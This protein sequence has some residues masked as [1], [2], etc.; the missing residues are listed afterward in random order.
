MHE[1]VCVATVWSNHTTSNV[2][3]WV[4]ACQCNLELEKSMTSSKML[5]GSLFRDSACMVSLL[6]KAWSHDAT[7]STLT[8]PERLATGVALRRNRIVG[9][10]ESSRMFPWHCCIPFFVLLSLSLSLAFSPS[11]Q[12]QPTPFSYIYHKVGAQTHVWL[13]CDFFFSLI[14]LSLLSPD[15]SLKGWS[16]EPLA[17]VGTWV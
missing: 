2:W 12:N 1:L 16:A 10:L 15:T 3:L 7:C 9:G 4:I 13:P 5:N 14:S 11:V 6:Q 8:D 17:D